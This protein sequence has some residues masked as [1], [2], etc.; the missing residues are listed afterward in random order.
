MK[1]RKLGSSGL[2]EIFPY[3]AASGQRYPEHMM[4]LVNR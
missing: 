3:G 2:D 1:T 4:A